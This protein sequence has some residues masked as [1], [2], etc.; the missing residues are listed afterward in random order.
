[1]MPLSTISPTIPKRLLFRRSEDILARAQLISLTKILDA[2]PY[3]DQFPLP[4]HSLTIDFAQSVGS[5]SKQPWKLRRR[6]GRIREVTSNG[7]AQ[8]R[9]LGGGCSFPRDRAADSTY[10]FPRDGAADSTYAQEGTTD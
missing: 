5:S 4:K 7:R 1:M 9:L 8:F 3:L 6:M 2:S 10:A